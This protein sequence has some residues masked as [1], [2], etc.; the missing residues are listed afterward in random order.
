MRGEGGTKEEAELRTR[1][2]EMSGKF[3][4]GTAEGR[5]GTIGGEERVDMQE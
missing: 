4:R 3:R 5:G 2:V 1:R